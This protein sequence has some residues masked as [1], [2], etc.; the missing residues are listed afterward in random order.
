LLAYPT[1][2]VSSPLPPG[3]GANVFFCTVLTG[4][5]DFITEGL[6]KKASALSGR[7]TSQ[8]ADPIIFFSISKPVG[9]NVYLL[10]RPAINNFFTCKFT[11]L[12][13]TECVSQT[14]LI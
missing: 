9:T 13:I 11:F 5:N 12:R 6:L 4:T 1:C 3:M 10:R 8:L 7:A 14:L 2:G